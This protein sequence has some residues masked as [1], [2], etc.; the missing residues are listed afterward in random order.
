MK[1]KFIALTCLLLALCSMLVGCSTYRQLKDDEDSSTVIGTVAGKNV[2]LDEFKF[3]FRTCRE[4]ML[5]TYGSD[6]FSGADAEYYADMLK[7]RVFSSIT[8]DYAVILLCEEVNISL[9]EAVI[10]ERVNEKMQE[11]TDELGGMHKYKKYLKENSLTD[12]LLRFTTEIS[13]LRNELLYVYTDDIGVIESDYDEL[14]DIIK[15]EFILV[16]HVFIPSSEA[17]VMSVVK[18]EYL[19]GVA[20]EELIAQ[21][22]K[23][24]Q[25][26]ADGNFILKG[27]MSEEYE[28][29]AFALKVGSVSEVVSDQNGLYLIERLSMP[30][31]AIMQSFERLKTLYQTYTF[32]D[33]I[34]QKQSELVFEINDTGLGYINSLIY[35]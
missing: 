25:M 3:A 11:L 2:Y 14:Y 29:A 27:Y 24:P 19:N 32:Y 18:E 23:D 20:F 9:G 7:E 6:I 13:L 12:R 26:S 15:K 1:N 8:A 5:A 31:T 16:R 33:I 34:D 21:Y 17:D 35:D 28:S 10:I 4:Q 30:S 22:N